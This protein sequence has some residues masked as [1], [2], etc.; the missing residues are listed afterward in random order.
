MRRVALVVHEHTMLFELAIAAEVFGVDR[1]DLSPSGRWY[2]LT[3][4]TPDGAPSPWLPDVPTADL[5]AL[6]DTDTV[7]VPSTSDPD[8]APDPA[9]L[10][11][12]VAAHD[13][14][15]RVVSLC[16]GAFLLAAAGLLDGREAATHWQHA[17][18][19]AARHPR[20]RVRDDVLY[21]VD[22]R[23]LTSAGKTAALDLCVHLVRADHGDAAAN[24][25]VRRLVGPGPRT[26]GQVQFI[27]RPHTPDGLATALERVRARLDR[28][29]SVA[30]L[31]REA[32]LSSRQLARRMRAEVGTGPLSWLLQ[33]RLAL[34]RELLEDTDASVEQ[35]AARCG[36]GTATTLRR[37]FRRSVG[38]SPTAY[39]AAV[40]RARPA[41][42]GH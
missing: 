21:V 37:H 11:A 25:L 1:A 28:P 6:R 14:G 26:G 18:Q 20:V 34:A 33:Q 23:V 16:T 7:V 41:A 19:L 5:S 36:L 35:I 40:D 39:R 22:G 32:G 2:D 3:V 38:T 12:L 29:F 4:C 24:G 30:D 13:R 17:D 15:A 10:A 42:R 8:A 31:A 9:L 27:A